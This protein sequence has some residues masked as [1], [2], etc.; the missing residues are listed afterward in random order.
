[1][2]HRSLKLALGSIAIPSIAICG[3]PSQAHR[4]LADEPGDAAAD[5]PPP[6]PAGAKSVLHVGDSTVGTLQFGLARE[7]DKRFKPL[8][9]RYN[10]RVKEAAGLR[11][12]ANDRVTETLV[13]ELNP[14]VVL[15]T[16]GTNN[17][18]VPSPDLYEPFVKSI[19][20]QVG[21]RPCIWVGPLTIAKAVAKQTT[22][23]TPKNP[24]ATGLAVVAMLK[25]NVGPC[26]FYDS[27]G[28]DIQREPDDVHPTVPGAGKWAEKIWS[29][30]G[31]TAPP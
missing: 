5:A 7:M 26:K 1:V 14:D 3:A 28:L 6:W 27:Y 31:P 25:K 11:N 23:D 9:I 24:H 21:N 10:A 16:L 13:R 17:L 18:S 8:N 12:F 29:F 22:R 20:S 15:F 4:A 2:K 19:V 30:L